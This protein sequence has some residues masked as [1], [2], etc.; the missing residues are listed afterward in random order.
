MGG[1][2]VTMQTDDGRGAVD[3]LVAG[4]AHEGRRADAEALIALGER[5]TG[6]PARLWPGKIIGCGTHHYRYES[7][8][9]GETA[10]FGFSPRAKATTLY[11]TSGGLDR[12]QH[13]LD[14]LGPHTTGSGCIYLT[15]LSDVDAG[16]L[17][18]LVAAAVADRREDERQRAG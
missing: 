5:V 18:E 12:Y 13:L 14:R 15:R 6:E 4:I 1:D 9:E 7:G 3:S 10:L 2:D 16:V 11:L 17:E 8:R